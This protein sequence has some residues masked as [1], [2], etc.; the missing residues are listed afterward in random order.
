MFAAEAQGLRALA[1]ANAA[2]VPAVR[3]VVEGPMPMLMLEHLAPA[4]GGLD[5]RQARALGRALATLHRVAQ[6]QRWGFDGDNYLGTSPQPNGW[7]DDVATFFAEQR[8][9]PQLAR[10]RAA[11]L[12]DGAAARMGDRL[13][14]RLPDLLDGSGPPCLLHGDLWSGNA[15]ACADGEPAILDPAAYYGPR[16]AEL[17]M[18]SLFGGFGPHFDAGYAEGWPLPPGTEARQALYQLYHVLNHLNLFGASYAGACLRIL[19]RFA[20]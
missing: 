19:R 7:R 15:L 6:A 16:E 1:A 8:L 4:P 12:L 18:A 17:A 13:L 2:R 3:A 20:G 11:G 10:A 14:A 9:G 5:A